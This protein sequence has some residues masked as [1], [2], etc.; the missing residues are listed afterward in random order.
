VGKA[1]DRWRPSPPAHIIFNM[2]PL[3][4]NGIASYSSMVFTRPILNSFPP[5]IRHGRNGDIR[6]SYFMVGDVGVGLRRTMLNVLD[7]SQ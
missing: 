7:S 3:D 4:G 2:L 1:R 6:W 5:P